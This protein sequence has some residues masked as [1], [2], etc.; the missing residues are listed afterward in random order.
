MATPILS[1]QP[2]LGLTQ[3]ITTGGVLPTRG[4]GTG[5]DGGALGSYIGVIHNFGGNF[6]PGSGEGTLFGG[7][8][9]I[10]GNSALFSLLTTQ[11]GGDGINTF[12]LPDLRAKL[13]D[14]VTFSGDAS[15][16]VT[17]AASVAL[18]Q[19][20]LP[21]SS[22]GSSIAV[23]DV[24]P[25]MAMQFGIAVQGLFPSAGNSGT[26]PNSV[27]TIVQFA[28]NFMPKG[29]LPAD[30]R[31][32]DVTI[33][34][35]L[36]NLIGTL[37]G[38][39]GQTTFGLPDLRDRVII[40]TGSGV[41]LG[42]TF[43][44]VNDTVS[45]AN[46][47]SN[48]GGGG[49]PID[50]RQPSIGLNYLV[51]TSGLFP[52]R[53]GSNT[54]NADDNPYLGEIIA[55]AHNSIPDGYVPADGRLLPISQYQGL[56]SVLGTTFGGNGTTNF[57]VPDLR[58]RAITN[59]GTDQVT[60]LSIALGQVLGS[61]T[62]S[63]TSANI[64]ALNIV[65]T[66]A[67][68]SFWGGDDPDNI[69]GGAGNDRLTGNDSSDTLDGGAG[70]DT[71][72]GGAGL[73]TASF[74]SAG[75]GVFFGL[76]SQGSAFN[77]Q[78][79]GTDTYTNFE[80]LAGGGFNDTLGGNTAA[81][82]LAGAAGDDA[83]YGWTE[84]D[85]LSGGTGN[86]TLYGGAGNDSMAGGADNDTYQV[87]DLG[88]VVTELSGQGIDIVYVSVNNWV[89]PA[90]VEAV[91]LAGSATLLGGGAADDQLVAQP[92]VSSSLSGAAGNDALWGG[93]GNDTLNGGAND[94][95]LRGGAGNDLLIGGT[96]SDQLVGGAG[97][98]VFRYDAP[99]WGYDQIFDFVQGVD[100]INMAGSGATAFGQL[101]IYTTQGSSV[102]EFNGNRIDVYGVASLTSS[103][104]LFV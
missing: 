95:A 3:Y 92:T 74:A 85:T 20:Q 88:D 16:V 87:E 13:S 73:D 78:G 82:L 58:G 60:G 6:V 67:N 46:M 40:G 2:M 97:A 94:D 51:A 100:V 71:L 1:L 19:A 21:P 104:F 29:Y 98:D 30:G 18:M 89:A 48:M 49:S 32:L 37:Y 7:S 65:G 52:S 75:T 81:N 17:G 8:K 25:T 66:G 64:P 53:S 33:Y 35:D 54:S 41:Q 50:A 93:A 34:S 55:V 61:D 77:T 62:Y 9:S 70:N 101:V 5:L 96:G 90:N 45:Q 91:Y 15:G 36:F 57:A 14:N 11:Y 86:D 80:N 10:A 22:G 76:L 4:D 43:G 84:N 69:A 38:G 39:D 103:D 23:S 44:A 59:A 31:L 42:Q 12:A 63:I 24:Q 47:P 72:D 83:L 68:E 102:V 27:G 56:F 79:A 26:L 28:G 99:G